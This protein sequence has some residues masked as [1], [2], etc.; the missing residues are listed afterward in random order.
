MVLEFKN[1][2][3]PAR[4]V[5]YVNRLT[6]EEKANVDKLAQ[7]AHGGWVEFPLTFDTKREV[8]L[9]ASRW[10]SRL[11]YASGKVRKATHRIAE[12]E[13]GWKFWIKYRY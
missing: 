5:Q 6:A 4:S 12:T 1:S 8:N 9:V 13:S 3:P 10:S 11:Y 2:D 7:L